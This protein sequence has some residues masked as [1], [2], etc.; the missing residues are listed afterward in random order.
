MVRALG[1]FMIYISVTESP[2]A[3]KKKMVYLRI[4][5]PSRTSALSL[6]YQDTA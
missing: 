4:P 1:T 6:P 3:V 5:E 2:L